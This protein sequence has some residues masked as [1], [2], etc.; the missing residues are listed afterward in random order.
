[1]RILWAIPCRYAEVSPDGQA[2][3]I[4]A[5]CDIFPTPALPADLHVHLAVS[6]AVDEHELG[7]V[8]GVDIELLDPDMRAA[9]LASIPLKLDDYSRR[10][11]GRRPSTIAVLDV[12]AEVHAHGMHTLHLRLQDRLTPV[13]LFV[14]N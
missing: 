7:L 13:S 5:G 1:V 9:R 4:G 8:D 3:L 2:T 6:I 11:A 14:T 10:P 12:R